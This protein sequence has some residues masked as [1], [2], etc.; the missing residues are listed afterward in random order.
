MSLF[1]LISKGTNFLLP[2][3]SQPQTER[4]ISVLS[5]TFQTQSEPELCSASPFPLQRALNLGIE[6]IFYILS[7]TKAEQIALQCW[8][9][10]DHGNVYHEVLYQ[11][12]AWKVSSRLGKDMKPYEKSTCNYYTER[13]RWETIE[14]SRWTDKSFMSEKHHQLHI[15]NILPCK[16]D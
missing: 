15:F 4:Y 13:V 2:M 5:S 8:R 9:R 14:C 11:G 1:P 7:R 16:K 3:I 10:K 6:K 12:A